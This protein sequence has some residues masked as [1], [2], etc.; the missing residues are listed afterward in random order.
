MLIELLI[1]FCLVGAAVVF[2]LPDEYAP[3]GALVASLFP[4]VTSFVMWLGFDAAGNALLGGELAYETKIPWISLGDY[5]IHWFVGVDGISMPLVV[6]ATVLTTLAIITAWTP[7]DDRRSQFYGLVLFMEAGLLGVFCS[8]DFFLWLVFWE[9][10]LIP[11]Y[12]LIG[13]WGGSDRRYAAIKF[14][15]YTNIATLVMFLGFMALV[16]GLGDAVSSF[17]LPAI[18]QA[19]RAGELQAL[20]GVAPSTIKAVA[21]AAMFFG[22]GVKMAIVPFHTWLPAAYSE[23]PTPVT[24]LLAGVVTKMGTYAML[25]FN[26]TMLR[27]IVQA[28]SQLIAIF[29]V[30]TVIYGALLALS[31][32]DL[33]RIVAYSSIPSMGFILLGL[34]AYTLYGLSG[35]VFQMVSH[36]LLTGLLFACVG[37]IYT[38]TDTRKVDEIGGLA[39]K[40]PITATAFVVGCF[41]YMGLP[42]ISGFMGEYFIFQGA[43]GSFDGSL[44]FTAIAMFGI[45]IIAGYY[46][47]AMQR[48][49]FGEF[50]L[51]TDAAVS[52]AAAHDIVP[53]V[54]LIAFVIA[55]G[56]APNII[57]GMISD[58][59][60]PMLGGGA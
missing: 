13:M 34:V 44:L 14:F 36:G 38:T 52:R 7:I 50:S 3:F 28:N 60:V 42:F 51:D 18:A 20:A 48:T 23:A 16:F 31:Q 53:L 35:A 55:L 41:G 8:L 29:A 21:F 9:A 26:F 6:L 56:V 15:V 32:R 46:L 57:F 39:G 4:L 1:V 25:R 54:V 2:L 33:K 24:V 17:S 12:L 22:F 59:V 58:A 45:V 40:M 19:L 43:F 5:T 30:V 47:F 49:L 10:V 37:I 11:S 27:D